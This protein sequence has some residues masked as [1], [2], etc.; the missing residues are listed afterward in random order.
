MAAQME[1]DAL[2]EMRA[3]EGVGILP[4]I[5][6]DIFK[7]TRARATGGSVVETITA[8]PAQN[9]TRVLACTPGPLHSCGKSTLRAGFQPR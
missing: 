7:R 9:K 3:E 1:A 5:V 4:R 8:R 6:S 2:A